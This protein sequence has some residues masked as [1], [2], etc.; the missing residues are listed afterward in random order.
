M[1]ACS[2]GGNGAEA[3][4]LQPRVVERQQAARPPPFPD[5]I[6]GLNSGINNLV[7]FFARGVGPTQRPAAAA[8]APGGFRPAVASGPPAASPPFRQPVVNSGGSTYSL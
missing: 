8:S 3:F 4:G 7:K 2:L 5:I 1:V 6:G